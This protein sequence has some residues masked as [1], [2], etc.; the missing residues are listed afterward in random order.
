[1][2]A[3]RA[4]FLAAFALTVT[5]IVGVAGY[6]F[7]ALEKVG[8][9][10]AEARHDLRVLR[11]TALMEDTLRDLTAGP[12]GGDG[13][14][15][16]RE[17]D[18]LL[19]DLPVQWIAAEDLPLFAAFAAAVGEA[20]EHPTQEAWFRAGEAVGTLEQA[21]IRS[22]RW[23]ETE[24]R[25]GDRAQRLLLIGA[26]VVAGFGAASALVFFR[27]RREEREA[28][29]HLRRSDRLAALGTVAASVAH[30][31]NNPLATISGCAAG[32]RDR[33]EREDRAR[34]ADSIDYLTMIGDETRRCSGIVKNLRD[35]A[36]EGP[37]AM[38]PAD[39]VPLAKS[40]VALLQVDRD[41]KPVEFRLEGEAQ[42]EALCDPDKVKQLLLNLLINARDASDPGGLVTVTLSR[43]A[44][45]VRI[46]VADTGRGIERR[47]LVRI[48]EPFH[49]DKTKGLGIGLFLCERIAALHRGTIRAESDGPGK[50]ARFV[51]EFPA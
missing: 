25:A 41:A 12:A 46:V 23:A 1:M 5:G 29:E 30:E 42:L 7:R 31:I 26:A 33:L 39:L 48:F 44:E 36:R 4:R 20:R 28:R 45:R 22:A 35:L 13:P 47:D 34:H 3:T 50:G 14:T 8:S 49:T 17:L 9:G 24:E 19:A 27:M 18:A 2:I 32:V 15:L 11:M 10:A 6:G 40:V 38:T 16:V 43:A 51:V 37:P 21:L